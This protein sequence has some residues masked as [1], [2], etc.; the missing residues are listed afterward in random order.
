MTATVSGATIS[1]T[2]RVSRQMPL[3]TVSTL[4]VSTVATISEDYVI[5]GGLLWAGGGLRGLPPPLY[6]FTL[7]FWQT[8][9]ERMLFDP[10]GAAA[11]AIWEKTII[12][13]GVMLPPPPLP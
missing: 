10:A 4:D 6:D 12:T 8:V 7:D 2:T 13:S 11:P 5:G 1:E 3:G 9:Y